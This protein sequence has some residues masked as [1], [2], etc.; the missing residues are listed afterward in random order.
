MNPL[1]HT[2]DIMGIRGKSGWDHKSLWK[3]A[4]QS[5]LVCS[6]NLAYNQSYRVLSN[7]LEHS[8]SYP[9]WSNNLE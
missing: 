9:V 2:Q 7:I 4:M 5:Y 8:Q 3:I 1:Y 6:N